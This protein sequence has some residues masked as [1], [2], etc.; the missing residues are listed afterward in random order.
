V[1][2]TLDYS[3]SLFDVLISEPALGLVTIAVVI[4]ISGC[5]GLRL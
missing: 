2:Q 4:N 1:A 5:L 3:V